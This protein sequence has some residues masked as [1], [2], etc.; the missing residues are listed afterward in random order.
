M[1]TAATIAI[2]A[3]F[4]LAGLVDCLISSTDPLNAGLAIS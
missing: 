3:S 2:A 1:E 4:L